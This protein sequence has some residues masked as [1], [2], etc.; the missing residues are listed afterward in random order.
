MKIDG[1]LSFMFYLNWKDQINELDDQELRR[2]INNLFSYHKGE[3]VVLETKIDKLVW[4]GILPGLQANEAKYERRR[5]ANR[6]NGKLGGAP[7][8]NQNAGTEK[9]TQNNPEQPKQPDNGELENDKSEMEMDN[10]KETNDKSEM[11]N[12][13]SK[14]GNDKEIQVDAGSSSIN[15]N[16]SKSHGGM[17]MYEFNKQR[18]YS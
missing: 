4:Q 12:E 7:K 8:G 10:S 18:G 3:A 1:K 16:N 11:E 9:T 17:S 6:E 2:L 15:S 14:M 5:E 13:K